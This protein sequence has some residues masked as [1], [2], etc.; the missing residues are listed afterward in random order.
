MF[1]GFETGDGLDAE[2]SKVCQL[3]LGEAELGAL[4]G[5]LAG[6]GGAHELGGGVVALGIG[7]RERRQVRD[8]RKAGEAVVLGA[9]EH[10]VFVTVEVEGGFA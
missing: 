10:D 9:G 8:T 3:T 2:A 4:G 1:A 6:H 5:E 7:G